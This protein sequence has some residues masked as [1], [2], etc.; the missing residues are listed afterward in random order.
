MSS[1]YTFYNYESLLAYV[2]QLVGAPLK[3]VDPDLAQEMYWNKISNWIDE[4]ARF[5]YDADYGRTAYEVNIEG[6]PVIPGGVYEVES[7]T[8]LSTSTVTYADPVTGETIFENIAGESIGGGGAKQLPTVT[9]VVTNASTGAADPTNPAAGIKNAGAGVKVPIANVISALLAA[10]GLYSAGITMSNWHTWED[11]FNTVFP[12]ALPV[13]ATIDDVKA[14]AEY[15]W[16]LYIGSIIDSN[17]LQAFVPE[18]IVT[19]LYD[20]LAA[21]MEE[22]GTYEG[23]QLDLTYMDIRY[24]NWSRDTDYSRLYVTVP[25]ST[26]GYYDLYLPHL[27]FEEN[28]LK[29]W[30]LDAMAQYI[31]LGFSVSNSTTNVI[32]SG[33]EYLTEWMV[34]NVAHEVLVYKTVRGKVELYRDAHTPKSQPVSP[35]EITIDVTFID[36]DSMVIDS[37]VGVHLKYETEGTAQQPQY[38]RFLKYGYQGES[39]YDYAYE[40]QSNYSYS[41]QINIE[42]IRLSYPAN[43]ITIYDSGLSPEMWQGGVAY[44]INGFATDNVLDTNEYPPADPEFDMWFPLEYSNIGYRGELKNY[45]PDSTISGIVGKDDTPTQTK[46]RPAASSTGMAWDDW[47]KTWAQR[48]KQ[49]GTIAKDG[50]NTVKTD[51]P[52][53]VPFSSEKAKQIIEHGYNNPNDT[54]SY[55]DPSSQAERQSG[56]IPRNTPIEDINEA[57]KDEVD[58]YNDSRTVPD[59]LPDPVPASEPLPQY[60]ETPPV[61]PEGDS[62]DTPEPSTMVGVTASGMC[63]VYNPTKQELINFSAWLW[64]PN[65]LENFLKIF[66]NP[67]DAIIGLHIMYATPATTTPAN[68]ICGYLDSGVS[69]KVVNQQFTEIDCGTVNVPEYYGNAIDYEPYAQVHCYLPFIGIVSLKPNDIIGKQLN[70]KYGVDAMTGTCLAILT[71]KKGDSEIACYNFAG[72]CAAQIPVSGGSYAQMITG[73]AGFVASGVGA[74]ATANPLMA[75]G[76]GASLLNSHLDVGHSGAIGANAGAMGIRKPYLIITRKSA[77]EAAGYGAF[78]GYPANKTVTLGSCKGYTRIKSVHVEIP[79]ATANEK[80]EIEQLLKQG[81]IIN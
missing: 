35:S 56:D 40:V 59:S 60:P 53:N 80:S 76:A 66:Q 65:F 13:P 71:T 75:L 48:S 3:G 18:S 4:N 78:Y 47:Y 24:P 42:T 81:V 74:V 1:L 61:E 73:L 69:A 49:R 30:V 27:Y 10:Y 77:Y 62:G 21:H 9:E 52:V 63:S 32:M 68:I 58:S 67:M 14:F 12:G 16:Q 20:Y 31:G 72:N 5:V 29:N 46:L 79:R 28:M 2:K 8:S 7:S 23:L 19:R 6:E 17:E 38:S 41:K 26:P 34:A 44:P 45:K 37:D 50:T 25:S 55:Q 51:V 43:E 11:V 70:I 36:D 15:K 57:I 33:C 39:H 64:S 54:N 22:D